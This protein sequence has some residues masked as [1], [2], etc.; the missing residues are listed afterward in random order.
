MPSR[1]GGVAVDHEVGLQAAV[2]L[3]ARHVAQLRQRLQLR[4]EARRPR[5]PARS[6]SAIFQAVLKLRAADAVFDRQVLHRLHE[7]R[8]A[9]DLGQLRLQAA[10]DVACASASRSS[11]GFRL[12]WMRPLFSVVFVP[13]TPMNDERLSTAGSCRI[14]CASACC[15][16]RHRRERDRLRRFRDAQDHAGV[17][18]R[19]EALGHDD[20]QQDRSRPASPTATSSVARLMPQ[21]PLQRPAVARDD[22]LEDALR[23][24]VEPAL[25]RLRLVPQQLARTSSA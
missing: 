14:T 13:S 20:V 15:R 22:A 25:L 11:S 3:V 19:E 7:E 4:H 10:D 18:H 17:L 12:I 21:H 2:L 23:R 5:A 6:A 8:D 24:A 9:L 16:S 1:D